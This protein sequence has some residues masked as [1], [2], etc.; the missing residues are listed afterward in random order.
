MNTNKKAILGMLVAM[1]MS[2]GVMGGMN[3]KKET[4]E[5]NLAI[6]VCVILSD[7]EMSTG[8]QIGTA[9]YSAYVSGAI[10]VMVG[11]VVGAV[12]GAVYGF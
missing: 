7:T 12:C 5:P 2:L 1:V 10:G 6:A 9:A 8:Q 4:L 3:Q 11:G